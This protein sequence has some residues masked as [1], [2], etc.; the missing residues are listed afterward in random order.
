LEDRKEDGDD[1]TEVDLKDLFCEKMRKEFPL[2]QPG[3]LF[4]QK[5]K[6]CNLRRNLTIKRFKITLF[7]FVEREGLLP[8]S[9]EP[10]MSVECS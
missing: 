2:E 1:N 6:A 7:R 3:V 4:P 10:S 9:E 5:D 8:C